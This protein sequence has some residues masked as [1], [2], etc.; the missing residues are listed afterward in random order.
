M[1]RHGKMEGEAWPGEDSATHN[2]KQ[3]ASISRHR[4][5]HL[6]VGVHTLQIGA[7]LK[8]S[9]GFSGPGPHGVSC[10]SDRGAPAPVGGGSNTGK[11]RASSSKSGGPSW[12]SSMTS[13]NCAGTNP[14]PTATLSRRKKGPN[15]GKTT[16]GKGTK[17]MVLVDAAGTSAGSIPGG[18]IPG[19]SHPPLWTRH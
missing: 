6:G 11:R 14:A 16:R 17:W 13:R 7:V 3:S 19:G 4:R 9:S 5:L 18:G 8:A 1:N 12:P 2:G 10:R 15:V